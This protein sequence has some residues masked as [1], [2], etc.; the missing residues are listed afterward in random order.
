[1]NHW[2]LTL[3][4]IVGLMV[5]LFIGKVYWDEYQH[6]RASQNM[7]ELLKILDSVEIPPGGHEVE[8]TTSINEYAASVWR[9]YEHDIP[10]TDLKERVWE[11][12]EPAGFSFFQKYEAY[13]GSQYSFRKGE[14]EV[15]VAEVRGSSTTANVAISVNWYG[16]ER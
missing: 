5:L 10:V 3:L 6:Y 1:M 4:T 7:P 13:G 15:I 8:T 9:S 12:I 2:K 16:L 11:Q 14:Y